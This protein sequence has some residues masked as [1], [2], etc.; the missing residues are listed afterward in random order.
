MLLET[1]TANR[2]V[3]AG[4]MNL[5]H[6]LLC[7]RLKWL[8]SAFIKL[9]NN[10]IDA[11]NIES[12]LGNAEVQIGPH[13]FANTRFFL[14]K[15]PKDGKIG[16]LAKNSKWTNAAMVGFEFAENV[17]VRF[18]LPEDFGIS[19]SDSADG[20]IQ[21]YFYAN[22]AWLSSGKQP[23]RVPSI[24][25]QEQTN[26]PSVDLML[27]RINI[28]I[29]N[30]TNPELE[31]ALLA[32]SKMQHIA[33]CRD[34]RKGLCQ[35][36]PTVK[37]LQ[38]FFPTEYKEKLQASMAYLAKPTTQR[39]SLHIGKIGS[40]EP[41]NPNAI[42]EARNQASN[43]NS[44]APRG[45][46][47]IGYTAAVAAA[48]REYY[49][50]S[51]DAGSDSDSDDCKDG[52]QL[53]NVSKSAPLSSHSTPGPRATTPT[54]SKSSLGKRA[55]TAAPDHKINNVN[56]VRRS[57]SSPTSQNRVCKYCRCTETP[58]W[59]RGPSGAGTLCNACGVKWKLGKILQ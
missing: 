15:Q 24:V 36:R 8:T 10:T 17:D 27:I 44:V 4:T 16:L 56:K 52:E 50:F 40:S 45:G 53:D 2:S 26:Y 6:S 1:K 46:G 39:S 38:S 20:R 3:Y 28:C 59:R 25:K 13:I 29:S 37:Y 51:R 43:T 22:P 30:I 58:I 33:V 23:Q 47:K 49:T 57:V 14:Q 48:N 21:A 34:Y 9:D 32:Y 54:L 12:D 31:G 5:T 11:L 18:S 41:V 42:I 55:R 35:K 19:S 7:S